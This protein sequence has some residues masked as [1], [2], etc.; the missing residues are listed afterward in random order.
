MEGRAAPTRLRLT[1]SARASCGRR[2]PGRRTSADGRRPAGFATPRGVRPV[3]RFPRRDSAEVPRHRVLGQVGRLSPGQPFWTGHDQPEQH[4][5]HE[6][7]PQRDGNERPAHGGQALVPHEEASKPTSA[8]RRPPSGVHGSGHGINE[9]LEGHG[10][11][12]FRAT[13]PAG[14]GRN[15]YVVPRCQLPQHHDDAG[16]TPA[17]RHQPES[18][19]RRKLPPLL[20]QG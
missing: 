5:P 17:T 8:T 6:R 18:R 2:A 16:R 19:A 14:Q 20:N 10:T 3:A 4:P 7:E 13:S 1:R 11:R 12:E 15:Q 9:R